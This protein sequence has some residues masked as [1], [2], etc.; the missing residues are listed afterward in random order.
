MYCW[1]GLATEWCGLKDRGTAPV[2]ALEPI[3]RRLE[4]QGASVSFRRHNAY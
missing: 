2:L 3:T 4:E 1:V